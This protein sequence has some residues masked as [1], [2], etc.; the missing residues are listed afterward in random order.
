VDARRARNRKTISAQGLDKLRPFLPQLLSLWR[1][2]GGCD[3]ATMGV[4]VIGQNVRLLSQFADDPTHPV[5]LVAN[6]VWIFG[7]SKAEAV[8]VDAAA[9]AMKAGRPVRAP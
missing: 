8:S 2:W 7:T 4:S 3:V 6:A 5:G 1:G 9:L